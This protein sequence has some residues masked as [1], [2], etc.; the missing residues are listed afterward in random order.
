MIKSGYYT[1]P[2]ILAVFLNYDELVGR[3]LDSGKY[4]DKALLDITE[5]RI[6]GIPVPVYYLSRC[7]E[8]CLGHEFSESFNPTAQK[9]YKSAKNI[10]NLFKEKLG[11]E[12]F[13]IPF[14]KIFPACWYCEKDTDEEILEG[15][16][17]YYI[18]QGRRNIDLDLY[19]A[20]ETMNF[21]K[22]KELLEQGADPLYKHCTDGITTILSKCGIECSYQ[23]TCMTG[24]IIDSPTSWI[25]S[26]SLDEIGELFRWAANEAMWELL[27]S[28][29]TKEES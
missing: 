14:N 16:R 1:D 6:F 21:E 10:L 20:V 11:I 8:I 22:A 18:S 29:V 12:E 19:I 28:Y 2:L 25:Y 27:N 17:N 13:S 9:N 7:W 24:P 3:I 15:P 23:A 5:N 4:N 26:I